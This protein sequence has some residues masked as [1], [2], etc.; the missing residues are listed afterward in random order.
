VNEDK[1]IDLILNLFSKD[2]VDIASVIQSIIILNYNSLNDVIN[3][4]AS[5]EIIVGM[6]QKN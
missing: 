6:F 3:N 2:E 4:C 1:S 5:Q